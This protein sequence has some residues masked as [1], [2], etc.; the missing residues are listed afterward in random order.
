VS[1][2]ADLPRFGVIQAALRNTTE[3]LALELHSP[4]ADAPDWNDFEWQVARAVATMHGISALLANRLRWRGP[5]TWR[6]FLDVQNARSVER[7]ALIG[8]LISRLDGALRAEGTAAVGLKGTALRRFGLYQPGERPQADVDLLV[9]AAAFPA[10]EA[11][12]RRLDYIHT[13]TS[14]RHAVYEPRQKQTPFPY[15]EHSAHPLKIEVHSAIGE[16]LPFRRVDITERVAARVP[17]AGLVEY[18][19]TAALMAH[20]LLHLAGNMRAHA[21]R[22]VQLVD[23]ARLAPRLTPDEWSS[24]GAWWAYP[25]LLLTSRCFPGSVPLEVLDAGERLCSAPLRRAARRWQLVDVSW[26]NLRVH[27]LPGIWWARTPSDAARFALSRIWPSRQAIEE[28][29]LAVRALPQL[30]SGT[31]WYTLSQPRRILRW[32]TSR[33]PRVQTLTC[34][35]GAIQ[36]QTLSS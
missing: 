26:S 16:P 19:D 15:G 20:L 28:L 34:V 35:R 31:P 5:A 3:R 24:I 9:D 23:I 6:E 1:A 13:F 10:V 21:L 27:A 2:T 33:P 7:D 14:R 29:A 12:T 36:D 22:L 17:S 4:S 32:L 30:G 18:P 8:A 25:P 11:A